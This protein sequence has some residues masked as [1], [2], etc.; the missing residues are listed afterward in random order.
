MRGRTK[1]R[2]LFAIALSVPM[3][4][5]AQIPGSDSS[6]IVVAPQSIVALIASDSIDWPTLLEKTHQ[7]GD[8]VVPILQQSATSST[9]ST[10]GSP[11]EERTAKLPGYLSG[12]LSGINL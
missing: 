8:G 1:M 6:D 2:I 5:H 4:A 12:N 7:M 3:L 9:G 10:D 11:S